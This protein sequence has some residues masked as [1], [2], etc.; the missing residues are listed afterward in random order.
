VL[1]AQRPLGRLRAFAWRD[2]MA[3][4]PVAGELAS[5]VAVLLQHAPRLALRSLALDTASDAPTAAV[6]LRLLE[7][8]P[9]LVAVTLKGWDF[10]CD[11]VVD[12]AVLE[13]LAYCLRVQLL[14]VER[15]IS[16]AMLQRLLG[17]AD[18]E[19]RIADNGSE[20]SFNTVDHHLSRRLRRLAALLLRRPCRSLPWPLTT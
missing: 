9:Y 1:Q 2:D 10:G 11:G 8:L 12:D 20:L 14:R 13:H 17:A 3:W 5:V 15:R 4:S 7:A 19:P 6:L 18:V 16:L